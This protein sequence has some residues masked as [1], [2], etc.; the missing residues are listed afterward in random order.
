MLNPISTANVGST[1]RSSVSSPEAQQAKANSFGDLLAG[2]DAQTPPSPPDKP[3]TEAPK[4]EKE[5]PEREKAAPVQTAL[6]TLLAD[7]FAG[8]PMPPQQSAAN[9]SAA[10]PSTTP[11]TV[12]GNG[13]TISLK[14]LDLAAFDV[15]AIHVQVESL[16]AAGQQASLPG[17]VDGRFLAE[18]Q[19]GLQDVLPTAVNVGPLEQSLMN[20]AVQSAAQRPDLQSVEPLPEGRPAEAAAAEVLTAIPAITESSSHGASQQQSGDTHEKPTGDQTAKVEALS[21]AVPSN[22]PAQFS[23]QLGSTEQA[24]VAH[25]PDL[26]P[27]TLMQTAHRV[28]IDIGENESKV[29][30]TLH[31]R[32]GDVSVKI[33]SANQPLSTQLQSSVGSLVEALHREHV[34][35]TNMDFSSGFSDQGQTPQQDSSQSGPRNRAK[36]VVAP[37]PALDEGF[38]PADTGINIH[39]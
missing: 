6:H 39:V 20:A 10:T 13:E 23:S 5:K 17:G 15:R 1:E 16:V 38:A 28:S 34:S 3:A 24:P 31:E 14:T 30:V 12:P 33:H 19:S 11:L 9:E 25:T 7:L 37:V 29:T 8:N 35:L 22:A 4:S 21:V 26:P 36:V 18:L 32:G 27:E 2:A